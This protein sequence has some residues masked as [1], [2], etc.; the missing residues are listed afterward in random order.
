MS[1]RNL[2][3]DI[4]KFKCSLKKFLQVGSFYS[5]DEYYKWKTR[6]DCAAYRYEFYEWTNLIYGSIGLLIYKIFTH[7]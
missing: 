5:L 3:K 6:D 1:I 2:S 7:Y 4:K